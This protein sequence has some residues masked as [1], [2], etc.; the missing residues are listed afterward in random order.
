MSRT[1]ERHTTQLARLGEETVQ[2]LF[3]VPRLG[4]SKPRFPPGF[5]VI[6][7]PSPRGRQEPGL[8]RRVADNHI[9]VASVD[10]KL[11]FARIQQFSELVCDAGSD[12]S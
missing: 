6:V 4:R 10:K 8:H 9:E 1:V 7:W 3:V 11:I 12:V 2:A 5:L